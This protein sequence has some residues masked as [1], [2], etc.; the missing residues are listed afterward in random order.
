MAAQRLIVGIGGASGAVYGI[1]LLEILR[2]MPVEAHLV[3]TRA[4][5][6]TIAHETDRKVAEVKALADASYR[7]DDVGAAPAS[8]SF[9]TI[10]MIVA[11]CS[12]RSMSEIAAGLGADLLTRAADVTI[13]ER[14]PLVLMVRETPLNAI[15][16]AN[17]TRLAEMGVTVAPPVPAFY[18]RPASLEEMVDHT[19][20]R[21]LDL[22]ALNAPTAPRWRENPRPRR[23]PIAHP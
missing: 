13:K 15:H 4:G 12:V 16:L 22:F 2:G 18:A 19:V 20:A 6:R 7:I 1:R 9:P 11:P 3:V 8:G 5:A 14:R 10:G 17:M 21:I 23:W